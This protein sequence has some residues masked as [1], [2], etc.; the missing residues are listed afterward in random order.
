MLL[1]W[2][3][4]GTSI[5]DQ[6]VGLMADIALAPTMSDLQDAYAAAYSVA[7]GD[8]ELIVRV[9]AEKDKRKLKL[10]AAEQ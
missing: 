3:N 1:E 8:E 9:V 5:M 6:L 7:R 4:G 10:A 2:L